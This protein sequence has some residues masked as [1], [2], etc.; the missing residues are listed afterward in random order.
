MFFSYN[1]LN[2][3]TPPPIHTSPGAGGGGLTGRNS[4]VIPLFLEHTRAYLSI[5]RFARVL[6][7]AVVE[8]EHRPHVPTNLLTNLIRLC[9]G[10]GKAPHIKACAIVRGEK[11]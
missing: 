8:G 7:L 11:K 5:G 10:Y 4:L 3:S 2:I 9:I 6:F 1:I